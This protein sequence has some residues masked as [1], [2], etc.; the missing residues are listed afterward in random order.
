MNDSLTLY[1][2]I[3]LESEEIAPYVT[4]MDKLAKLSKRAGFKKEFTAAEI[5]LIE[6][7]NERAK[8]A[9]TKLIE[10]NIV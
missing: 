5:D 6:A 1:Y 9:G 7:L 4:V 10:A 8:E 3:Q 2:T